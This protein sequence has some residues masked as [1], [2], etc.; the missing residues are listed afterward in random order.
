[1]A[2]VKTSFCSPLCIKE[3]RKK[4]P[5]WAVE[6]TPLVSCG[7][8]APGEL[9]KRWTFWMSKTWNIAPSQDCIVSEIGTFFPPPPPT[10]GV[11]YSE[12][13]GYTIVIKHKYSSL[14]GNEIIDN[15][16]KFNL[17]IFAGTGKLS[18][19]EPASFIKHYLIRAFLWPGKVYLAGYRNS[20]R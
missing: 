19:F 16:F 1:M 3:A 8:N 4:R 17:T 18:R 2:N 13:L 5:W 6:K 15:F 20:N 7:K 10:G 9:W 12:T 11:L 14:A